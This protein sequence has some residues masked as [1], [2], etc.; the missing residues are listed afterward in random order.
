[1][2]TEKKGREWVDTT[3]SRKIQLYFNGLKGVF[4]KIERG[5]RL[6]A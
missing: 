2:L 1:M 3:L 5:Y 6:T 4:A